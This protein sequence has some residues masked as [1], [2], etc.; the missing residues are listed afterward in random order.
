MVLKNAKEK[1]A[2]QKNPELMFTKF[3]YQI[4]QVTIIIC[5]LLLRM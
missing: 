3:K 5:T 2:K 1:A 4:F